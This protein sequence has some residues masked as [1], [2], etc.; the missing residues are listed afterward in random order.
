MHDFCLGG[1]ARK[2][3]QGC[4][5][6]QDGPVP[7]AKADLAR[8][9][10]FGE[11]ADEGQHHSFQVALQREAPFTFRGIHG[12]DGVGRAGRSAFSNSFALSIVK[13]GTHQEQFFYSCV[14]GDTLTA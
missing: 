14:T 8:I 4:I 1:H 13:N 3:K 10:P 11:R 5:V 2:T 7:D 6:A 9:C 12:H